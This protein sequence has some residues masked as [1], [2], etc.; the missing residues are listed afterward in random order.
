MEAGDR[1]LQV[2]VGDARLNF[3]RTFPNHASTTPRNPSMAQGPTFFH[4][5]QADHSSIE[6]SEPVH[7]SPK[8]SAAALVRAPSCRPHFLGVEISQ[9]LNMTYL[10]TGVESCSLHR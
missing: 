3:R 1:V 10:P 9:H 4:P 2:A 6:V 8:P 5:Q 7:N